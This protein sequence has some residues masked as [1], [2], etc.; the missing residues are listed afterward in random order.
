MRRTAIYNAENNPGKIVREERRRIGMTQAELALALGVDPSMVARMELENHGLDS[1]QTRRDIAKALGISPFLLGV[2]DRS[3]IKTKTV[4]NIN[5]LKTALGMHREAYFTT[6]NFGIPAV[7]SM[8][9]EING[10][11]KEHD[12]A[13]EI[14]EVFVEYNILGINIG[15]EEM[16]LIETTQYIENALAAARSLRSPVL[17]ADALSTASY[18]MYELGDMSEAEKY[19]LEANKIN[20]LPNHLKGTIVVDLAQ[21]TRDTALIKNALSLAAKDND[22]PALK[23]TS[24]YCLIRKAFI[25]VAAGKYNEALQVLDIAQGIVPKNMIRRHCYIHVL[26]TQCFLATEEYDQADLVAETA[27]QTARDIKSGP[28]L[29]RLRRLIATTKGRANL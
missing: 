6:G 11:L 24:D 3:E 29:M 17:L 25:L 7:N 14:L 27:L 23:L 19:A 10:L 16:Q 22:Y 26:Q 18:A 8:I 20:K 21:A 12:N 2:G 13:R 4:Y 1:V 5:I 15:R 9:S 28:N